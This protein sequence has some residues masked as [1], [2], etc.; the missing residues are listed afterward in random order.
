MVL[1]MYIEDLV[2]RLGHSGQYMFEDQLAIHSFDRPIVDSLANQAVSY[3]EKQQALALRLVTKYEKQ[4]STALKIDVTSLL[5]NPLFKNPIRIL[6][7]AKQ[8]ALGESVD[9]KYIAVKFPYNEEI[10]NAIKEYKNGLTPV[11]SMNIKW[12]NDSKE[13]RFDLNE[14]NILFLS[15]FLKNGFSADKKFVNYVAEVKEVENNFVDYVPIVAFEDGKFI[16]KNVSNNIPQPTSTDLIDVLL[17]ARKYGIQCWDDAIDRVIQ[18]DAVNTSLQTIFKSPPGKPVVLNNGNLDD[19]LAVIEDGVT[20]FV[21]PGGL[22]IDHLKT[23]HQF[24]NSKGYTNDILSVMFRLDNDGPAGQ[25][26]NTYIKDNILNNMINEKTKC[27][28]ISGKLTKAIIESPIKIDNVIHFGTSSAHYILRNYVR[29]HNNVISFT[30]K[31]NTMELPIGN[32]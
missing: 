16:Y 11:N 18:T 14:P 6:S 28:F 22:E 24:L 20:L 32:L 29:Y 12:E 31:H 2:G 25:V 7:S 26:F 19:L 30:L 13:W 8:I 10:V 4:L 9:L 21:L 27:A 3:T 17:N 23:V 15:S 1:Y 5:I